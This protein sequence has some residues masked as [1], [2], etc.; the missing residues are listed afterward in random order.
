MAHSPNLFT[1]PSFIADTTGWTGLTLSG[2]NPT[3]SLDS[4][5]P[6]YGTGYSAKITLDNSSPQSGLKTHQDYRVSVNA[7]SAYTFSAYVKV[8]AG[9]ETSDFKLR[10]YFYGSTNSNIDSVPTTIS[11]YDGWV[12]LVFSFIVPTGVTQF[13]GFVYRSSTASVSGYYFLVDALQIET[14]TT[15]SSLVYDQGQKNKLVDKSLSNVYIDHLTGMKLKADIRLGDFVFNRIDEYG[16]VWVVSNIEGWWNLPE[17]SMQDLPRGWGDG[18]YTTFGRFGSRQLTITGSFLLQDTDTQLEAARE[19]LI[20]AINLVKKDAWLVLDEDTPKA[21]KVRL[22]GTPEI[23]TVNPRGKTDFSIGLVAANPIKFKWEDARDDGYALK[24]ITNNS[25]QIIRNDG[26]TPVGVIFE[27]IGPTTGPTSLFN[28]TSEQLL[29]VIYKLD[30][31]KTYSV[32]T[33]QVLDGNLVFTTNNNEPHG[34]SVG[35]PIDILN[36]V[37]TFEISNVICAVNDYLDINTRL[38]H[39]FSVGQ[40]I[41]LTGINAVSGYSA[42]TDGEYAISNVYATDENKF[43][44]SV[45]GLTVNASQTTNTVPKFSVWSNTSSIVFDGQNNLA[46]VTTQA[47]HGFSVQDQIVLSNVGAVYSG[48]HTITSVPSTTSFEVSLYNSQTIVSVTA[49]EATLSLGTITIDSTLSAQ[50]DDYI[51]IDGVNENF[52]GT[53]KVVSANSTTITFYK[54]F[55]N[56]IEPINISSNPG[57]VYLSDLSSRSSASFTSG[58]AY[59]GNIFNGSYNVGS[60]VA[61]NPN[62]FTVVRPVYYSNLTTS[63]VGAYDGNTSPIVRSYAETL[64]IDTYTKEIAINGEIGGYR[65]KLDTVVDWIELQPGDNE[66]SFD[67]LN[68]LTVIRVAYDHPNTTATITTENEHGYTVN[69]SVKIVGLQS[70]DANVFANNSTVVVSGVPNTSS[71]T[72]TPANNSGVNVSSVAVTTGYVYEVSK[73]YVN[74]YYRSGWIG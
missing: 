61:S 18:S 67:D 72:F 42:V 20:K 14:G 73:A 57:T 33:T 10:A 60:I 17:V 48:T 36:I 31:Y 59:Y 68:K 27:I 56:K 54:E 41:Y 55:S 40:R 35:D 63:F 26:N 37:D 24:T 13:E 6:L 11:S 32:Y 66:I 46:T 21:L 52:N 15:A 5:S 12:R 49:Y 34:F 53:H 50:A 64:S 8:P 51:T 30:K 47:A 9:K 3:I 43:R 25:S 7:G 58:R 23:S 44:I 39:N 28:K 62:K 65:A 22:S 74:V 70:N 69:S 4:S 29:D 19:R 45:S 2:T 71:F 1:N 16:V 38:K